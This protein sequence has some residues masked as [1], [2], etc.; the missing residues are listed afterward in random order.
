MDNGKPPAL[1]SRSRSLELGTASTEASQ[2]MAAI[3]RKAMPLT[4]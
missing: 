2:M 4:N 1:P 3:L